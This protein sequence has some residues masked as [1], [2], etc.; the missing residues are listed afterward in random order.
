MTQVSKTIPENT[1]NVES[2][3]PT[4]VKV[5]SPEVVV[6]ERFEHLNQQVSVLTNLL[7]D[8]QNNLKA[9]QKELVKLAKTNIKKGKSRASSGGKKTPS[10]FAKPT[11]LTDTLCD[12]LGVPHGTELAR[13]DVTRRINAYIKEHN[14]QDEKDKRKIHPDESLGKVL[15]CTEGQEVTFFT[16]QSNLK[17]N[18]I[19][20]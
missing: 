5:V 12:F 13:T 9:A 19:K 16:L 4:E 17:H 3:T 11:K 10:G 7:R 6:T 15:S 14:L 1:T 20:A 18:F 8:L 2:E